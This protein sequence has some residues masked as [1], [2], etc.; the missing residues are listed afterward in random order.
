MNN[1]FKNMVTPVLSTGEAACLTM[2]N[3]EEIGVE[4]IS[5]KLS[6]LLIKP[7]FDLLNTLSSLK[8]YVGW[9]KTIILNASM[10]KLN[11]KD[12][13]TIQSEFDGSKY[14]YTKNDLRDLIVNLAPDIV[15]LPK[16][17]FSSDEDA[18]LRL[19]E[20]TK[21]YFPCDNE[22]ANPSSH[23]YGV[24]FELDSSNSDELTNFLVKYKNQFK[25]IFGDLSMEMLLHLLTQADLFTESTRPLLDGYQGIIYS[26]HKSISI[27]DESARDSFQVIDADC[28]CQ[29]CKDGHTM[30]YL[31]HLYQ[32]TPLLCQRFLI[33]HNVFY[34]GHL[35]RA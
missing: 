25:Y 20:K 6:A 7:G 5:L 23:K 22:L 8:S 1:N 13:Y 17:L 4:K 35:R 34:A 28:N 21:L 27:L 26:N 31:H 24:H 33:L 2:Q 9:N 12:R 11:S 16:G 3:L 19:S 18:S 30:A 32:H 29:T 14:V 10:I 15:L